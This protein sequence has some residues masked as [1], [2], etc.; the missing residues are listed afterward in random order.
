M[1]TDDRS[2]HEK[3]PAENPRP[4]PKTHEERTLDRALKQTFPASDPVAE[5]PVEEKKSEEENAKESLLDDAV[6]MTFPASDPISVSSGITRI[7]KAPEMVN[8]HD[9]HQHIG[10]TNETTRKSKK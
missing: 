10:E 8:A 1:A 4:L 5:M 9:D 6:E 2:L 7:E 3:V